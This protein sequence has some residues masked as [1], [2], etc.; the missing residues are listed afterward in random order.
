MKYLVAIIV[1]VSGGIWFFQKPNN[2]EA[3]SIVSQTISNPEKVALEKA[4]KVDQTVNKIETKIE[5][6]DTDQYYVNKLKLFYNTGNYKGALEFAREIIKKQQSENLKNWVKLQLVPI[7]I[8]SGW[9][10]VNLGRCD[11]AVP[12]FSEALEIEKT[13]EALKGSALC[14]FKTKQLYEAENQLS[15]LIEQKTR[16]SDI[17]LLY[18]EVLESTGQFQIAIEALNDAITQ[19]TIKDASRLEERVKDLERKARVSDQQLHLT[20]RFLSV[21]YNAA[22]HAEIVNFIS[23]YSEETIFEYVEKFGFR[24][25]NSVIEV[26]LYEDKGFQKVITHSPSWAE[27]LFDGRIRLPVQTQWL[28]SSDKSGLIKV[29]RHELVHAMFSQMTDNRNLPVWFEE[30]VAQKLSCSVGK[31]CGDFLFAPV[32]GQFLGAEL[33]ESRFIQFDKLKANQAYRQ[34]LYLIYVIE[35][36]FGDSS[37][38]RKIVAGIGVQTSL[39]SESILKAGGVSFNNLMSISQASWQSRKSYHAIVEE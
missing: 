4:E 22:S 20:S 10:E 15:W 38:L 27:G 28:H 14:L 12:Y 32:E 23:E 5:F 7:L 24:E 3:S 37:V 19:N 9:S 25:P 33:V 1:L 36:E 11:V 26:V 29:L 30:G 8:S 2:R 13:P 16:D 31:G 17:Y 6:S 34:S 18:A 39:D 21:R 35:N